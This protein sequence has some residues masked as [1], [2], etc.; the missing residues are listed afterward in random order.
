MEAKDWK[1]VTQK[2]LRAGRRIDP[3]PSTP[4]EGDDELT[5]VK[6][7]DDD[8]KVLI[9]KNGDLRFHQVH[10]WALL[11]LGKESYWEW[12]VARMRNYMMHI[13]L[14]DGYNPRF[15]KPKDDNVIL[16]DHVAR[17]L[18]ASTLI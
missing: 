12:I 10:E 3:I 17:F 14:H 6:I 2:N 4:H 1:R 13:V 16:A 7:S 11:K 8:L 9:D 18:V 15:N 5:N